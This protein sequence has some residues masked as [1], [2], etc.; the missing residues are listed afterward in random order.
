MLTDNQKHIII[1]T[2]K[3]LTKLSELEKD[4]LDTMEE[5]SKQFFD[6]EHAQKR[7]AINYGKHPDLY[8]KVGAA[9]NTVQKY[10]NQMN[11]V[12]YR[13]ILQMQLDFL[14]EEEWEEK[15]HG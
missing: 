11:E 8:V 10:A 6:M 3:Q 15:H 13:Y 1:A 14:L 9:P 2:V 12:D 7:I 4:I 5:Y